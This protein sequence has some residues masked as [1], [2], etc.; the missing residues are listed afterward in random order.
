V[1]AVAAATARLTQASAGAAPRLVWADKAGVWSAPADS[2]GRKVK[3]APEPP[4]RAF[5]ASPDGARAVG[6]YPSEVYT[7]AHHKQP[8]ELLMGM[9]LDGSGARRKAIRNGVPI[10]WSHDGRWVL[11]QDGGKGCLMAATGGEYKCWNGFAAT[12]LA[13]DGSWA[14]LLGDPATV[15]ARKGAKP[16]ARAPVPVKGGAKGSAKPEA[17]AGAT[18]EAKVDEPTD[19]AGDDAAPAAPD[20]PAPPPAGPLGLYRG[21]L[22]G[23]FTDPPILIV[24]PV[25]GAAVWVPSRPAQPAHSAP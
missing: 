15:A 11:V 1:V 8:A 2:P 17:K 3:V 13:A 4:L 14:L 19:D 10:D 23:P 20:V 25:D 21:K 6:V 22:D 16:A 18:P 5:L 9:P 24:K 12:S 7:D